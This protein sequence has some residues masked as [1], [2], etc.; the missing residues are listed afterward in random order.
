[1]VPRQESGW[2]LPDGP[3]IVTADQVNGQSA[4]LRCWV[5]GEIRQAANT[6][7]LI[8]GIPQLIETISAGI[9][10]RAGDVIAT[11][12]PAGVGIGFNPPRYLSAG[13]IVKIEIE[14]IG[15]LENQ[16]IVG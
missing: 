16:V 8:F 10:L 13:D 5:N 2:L 11:G 1:M 6:R 3:Y 15:I 14:G 4:N 7:D 12:T 9:A